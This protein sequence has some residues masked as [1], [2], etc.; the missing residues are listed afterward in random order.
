[1]IHGDFVD[2]AEGEEV[3]GILRLRVLEI[4]GAVGVGDDVDLRLVERDGLDDDIAMEERPEIEDGFGAGAISAFLPVIEA[5]FSATAALPSAHM[6]DATS[7]FPTTAS[8]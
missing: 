5:I 7:G 2:D 3:F 4:P 1:V 8:A 6:L